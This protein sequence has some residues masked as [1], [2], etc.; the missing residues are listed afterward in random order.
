MGSFS[1][2]IKK[3]RINEEIWY[4]G[5]EASVKDL[6]VVLMRGKRNATEKKIDEQLNY[7]TDLQRCEKKLKYINIHN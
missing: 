6:V 4:A 5:F 7:I 2:E 3:L 1:E